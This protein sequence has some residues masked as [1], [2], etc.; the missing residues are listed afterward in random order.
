MLETTA[1]SSEH[2][3]LCIFKAGMQHKHTKDTSKGLCRHVTSQTCQP[4]LR[5]NDMSLHDRC[6]EPLLHCG[7]FQIHGRHTNK[8]SFKPMSLPG[9]S[10][11]LFALLQHREGM[12]PH[13]IRHRPDSC[14]EAC[15]EF[16]M[17][18]NSPN[19]SGAEYSSSV[20][21]QQHRCCHPCYH[22]QQGHRLV[23]L[24]LLAL[25]AL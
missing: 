24:E 4:V 8:H 9:S 1:R 12:A 6:A 17:M 19:A 5:F 3:L 25:A 10:S 18:F 23:L 7:D 11:N 2:A 13:N 14:I 15:Q 22:P 16:P 20:C 21:P